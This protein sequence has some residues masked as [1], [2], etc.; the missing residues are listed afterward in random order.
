MRGTYALARVVVVRG[1]VARTLLWIGLVGAVA[2]L[3]VP[4]L[5]GVRRGLMIGAAA[6]V[7]FTLIGLLQRFR[8]YGGRA[9]AVEKAAFAVTLEPPAET[10]QRLARGHALWLVVGMSLTSALG[11]TAGPAAGMLVFG[12][13]FGLF[14]AT[15]LQARWERSHETLLWARTEDGRLLGRR[16]RIGA[17]AGTG[18]A[19]GQVRRPVVRGAGR[20]R[21]A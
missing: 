15:R 20:V 11:L 6:F 10:R 16:S 3:I 21:R 18:P 19:A 9:K 14:C 17:F 8:W 5:T 1:A 13:G 2:G 7:L 12:Y 4:S